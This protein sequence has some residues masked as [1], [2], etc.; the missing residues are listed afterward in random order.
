M[1]DLNV[2]HSLSTGLTYTDLSGSWGGTVIYMTLFIL[3]PIGIVLIGLTVLW[4][5]A[6]YTRFKKYLEWFGKTFVYAGIGLISTGILAIPF[7]LLYWGYTQAKQGNTVPLR[8]T[9]YAIGI[10]IVLSMFGWIVN[11]L[12]IE[13]VQKFETELN[14]EKK[15]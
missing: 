3:L 10:Y 14:K 7:G 8:Y 12:V 4:N 1:A 11:K 15:K 9:G 2:T 6:S 13:R 5:I